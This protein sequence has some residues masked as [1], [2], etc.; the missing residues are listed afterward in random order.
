MKLYEQERRTSGGF[1]VTDITDDV[2]A[3]VRGSGIRSGIACVYCPHTT[4]CVRVNE[5]ETGLLE[6][7]AALLRRLFPRETS[8]AG[9]AHG[10]PHCVSM[11]LGPAGE[12]IPVSGGELLLGTWQRV[13]FVELD[14][15][16]D[17]RWLVEVVGSQW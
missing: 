12:S 17:G 5:F 2:N 3:A 7:F 15:E 8:D 13:L 10:H 1:T 4:C 14:R 16:H 9:L 11:L 6:D